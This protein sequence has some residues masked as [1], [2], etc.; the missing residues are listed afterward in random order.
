MN[1][2]AF[3]LLAAVSMALLAACTTPTLDDQFAGQTIQDDAVPGP[4]MD[5]GA[6]DLNEEWGSGT[7]PDIV[8]GEIPEER[9]WTPVY[10]AY[11]QSV[12]GETERAKLAKIYEYLSS[13]REF[14][15]LVE[16]HCDERGSEEYNRALGERRAIAIREYLVNL[17]LSKSRVHTLSYGE[18]RPASKASTEEAFRLNRR[19]ELVVIS[20]KRATASQ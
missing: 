10:F 14:D 17:G 5:T 15:L 12:I 3:A 16:G 8:T 9:R 19:A 11:D 4:V 1:R 7:G 13:N 18:E 20:A 2:R 6:D